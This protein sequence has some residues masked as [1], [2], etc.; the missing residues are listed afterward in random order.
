M[1]RVLIPQSV[2]LFHSKIDLVRLG[3]HD[4]NN[5]YD[6]ADHEDFV[7]A[8]TVLYPD[9]KLPEAYHDLALLRL[10]SELTLKVS[11]LHSCLSTLGGERDNNHKISWLLENHKLKSFAVCYLLT[12]GSH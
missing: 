11:L 2:F 4:Y 3:E 1:T 9:Y 10:E 7:V 6:F 8:E 5:D 12:P